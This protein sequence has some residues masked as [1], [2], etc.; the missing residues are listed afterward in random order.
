MG[1]GEAFRARP[2]V[3]AHNLAISRGGRTL[4]SGLSFSAH[5]GDYLELRGANGAG[6]T[7][8]LRALA[9]FLR[10]SE[11][12][13]SVSDVEEPALALHL[14][15]HRDGLKSA[16]SV[17][18]HTR[19]WAGLLGGDANATD[20]ALARV[21]LA[22]IADLPARALSQG[23]ARRLALTRLLVAPRPVWL[24]DEPAAGLDAN[25]K[26][27]LVD[28]IAAHCADGGVVIAALHEQLGAPTQTITLEPA[29]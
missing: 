4:F 22:A 23:Q 15:G 16:L 9:R 8:L 24:L 3:S 29:P 11:G 2:S 18:A 13:I 21:G 20:A 6:K 7:S 27:L 17:A 14:L 26:A 25:A 5:P 10:P 19:F 12:A 28:L 1:E